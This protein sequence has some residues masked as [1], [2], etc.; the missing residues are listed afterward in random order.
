MTQCFLLSTLVSHFILDTQICFQNYY[1]IFT[2]L[3]NFTNQRPVWEASSC[4]SHETKE[5]HF[6]RTLHGMNHWPQVIAIALQS[7]LKSDCLSVCLNEL[8]HLRIMSTAN[9]LVTAKTSRPA[10]LPPLQPA[11]QTVPS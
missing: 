10:N 6:F 4:L 11:F 3:H 8:S 1:T 2:V 7:A 9:V 5:H